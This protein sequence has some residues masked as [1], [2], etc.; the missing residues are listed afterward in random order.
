MRQSAH[1]MVQA[2]VFTA[3]AATVLASRAAEYATVISSTPVT[4]SVATPQR[5]CQDQQQLVQARPS[6]AGAVLGAIAGGVIGNAVGGGFGRAAAT[7]LGVV[8]G[9]AIGDQDEANANPVGETTVRRCRTVSSYAPR[10]VGYDV[11]Y[12][13]AGRRYTTRLANDPGARLA[14]DVRP[15]GADNAARPPAE[16]PEASEAPPAYYVPPVRAV[17]AA[18]P[19][20]YI[21]PYAG[22]YGYGYRGHYR[23]HY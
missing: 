15:A 7:G 8:A 3:L 20:V 14:V 12:E 10:V 5:V 2:F 19:W 22:Y 11:V 17:L 9:A 1:P 16:A 23:W 6:G 13:Y 4:A 21:G 18:P